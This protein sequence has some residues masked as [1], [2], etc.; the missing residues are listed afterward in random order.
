MAPPAA[1]NRQPS[2]PMTKRFVKSWRLAHWGLAAAVLIAAAMVLRHYPP[3]EHAFYPKCVLYE[4]TGLHCPGCGG[5]RAV[6]A[7]VRG[8]IANAI[9]FNPLLIVGLPLIVLWVSVQ[10]RRE[11]D[12]KPAAPRMIWLL[13]AT[14]VLFSIARNLPTPSRGWLAPPTPL[15][16]G[17][18][19]Y[20]GGNA[21][22]FHSAPAEPAIR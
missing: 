21:Y 20:P 18:S 16:A 6:A 13:F 17:H 10:R 9:Q 2:E 12:G 11:R 7:L 22:Q 19:S 3:S 1:I 5:T 15:P 8:R 4:S 14:L